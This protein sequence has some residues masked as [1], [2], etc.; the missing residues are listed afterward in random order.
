MS[1]TTAKTPLPSPAERTP[2]HG[3]IQL[4][5]GN[6]SQSEYTLSEDTL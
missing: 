5:L 1:E 4:P 2:R 6:L 3:S